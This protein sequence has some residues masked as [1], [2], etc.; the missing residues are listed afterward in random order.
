MIP[1]LPPHHTPLHHTLPLGSPDASAASHS[2]SSGW[3]DRCVAFCTHQSL[4]CRCTTNHH[5]LQERRLFVGLHAGSGPLARL[6]L[7]PPGSLP[8]RHC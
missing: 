8:P 6:A 2:S 5:L 4:L 7:R 3:S 1:T